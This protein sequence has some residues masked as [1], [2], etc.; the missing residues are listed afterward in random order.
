MHNSANFQ[1]TYLELGHKKHFKTWSEKPKTYELVSIWSVSFVI[2]LCSKYLVQFLFG[3]T[4][5]CLLQ[6]F[7]IT[8]VP[9]FN[10]TLSLF[11]LIKLVY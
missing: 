11:F 8:M 4:I 2:L 3:D 7:Q 1:Q 6:T 5:P 10:V 9:S